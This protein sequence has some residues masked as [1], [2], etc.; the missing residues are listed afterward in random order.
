VGT[1]VNDGT[2]RA[3]G[4]NGGNGTNGTSIYAH[5]SGG[6]G[7][8]S[9]GAIWIVCERFTGVGAIQVTGG[10]GGTAGNYSGAGGTGGTGRIRIDAVEDEGYTGTYT[11]TPIRRALSQQGFPISV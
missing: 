3:N 8:G 4:E 1:L 5:G 9:G 7:G 6:G 11:N 2:I 10:S